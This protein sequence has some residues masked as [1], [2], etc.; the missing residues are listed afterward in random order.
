M[1]WNPISVIYPLKLHI[2][3]FLFF[4][5]TKKKYSPLSQNSRSK[6]ASNARIAADKI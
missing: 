3:L 4:Q 5:Q 2:F 6:N 1:Q